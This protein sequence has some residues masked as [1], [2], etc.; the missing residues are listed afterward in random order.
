[1]KIETYIMINNEEMLIPY[2]MRHYGQFSKVIF[3][4]SNSTDNT[5][6][7]AH[8]LGAEVRQYDM[9]DEINDK[10]HLE[11]KETCW[12]SSD[13]DWV[14]VIDADEFVYHPEIIKL[15]QESKSTVIH[16]T[17]HNMFSETFP[18]TKGQ[19]YDEVNMGTPDGDFWLSKMVLFK[20]KEIVKMNWA[21]GCHYAYPEGN[22]IIDNNS[23]IKTLHMR[24]L[25]RQYLIDK[26]ERNCKRLSKINQDNGWG[27]QLAWNREKINSYFDEQTPKLIKIV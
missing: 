3:L 6:K 10:L 26:Y 5:V 21:I 19:I 13:A 9:P 25:S 7:L 16:P 12:K 15:L 27:I 1:M 14:I 23:G 17:F 20:P 18:V 22:V 2:I 24:F 8:E 4:E 11:M